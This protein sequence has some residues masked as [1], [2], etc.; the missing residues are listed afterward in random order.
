MHIFMSMLVPSMIQT[1]PNYI[2]VLEKSTLT[3]VKI[4][5]FQ[6]TPFR[7][8][9]E[10]RLVEC[11]ILRQSERRLPPPLHFWIAHVLPGGALRCEGVDR[12]VEI[13][14]MN[15]LTDLGDPTGERHLRDGFAKTLVTKVNASRYL[16]KYASL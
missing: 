3:K 13:S 4:P 14:Q 10:L 16:V 7:R 15:R 6:N 8:H 1:D 12:G 9:L 5:A 2:Y 11:A